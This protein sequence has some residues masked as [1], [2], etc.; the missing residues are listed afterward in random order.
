MNEELQRR[1]TTAVV[2]QNDGNSGLSGKDPE[3]NWKLGKVNQ[4]SPLR[5][6]AIHYCCSGEAW[7]EQQ[8]LSKTAMSE[9]QQVRLRMHIGKA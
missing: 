8:A 2:W 7:R 3:L 5:V 1:G 9:P 4:A 6:S